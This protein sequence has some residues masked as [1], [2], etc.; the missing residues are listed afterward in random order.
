[1]LEKQARE[2][3]RDQQRH[4]NPP[5]IYDGYPNCADAT[6]WGPGQVVERNLYLQKA[7]HGDLQDAA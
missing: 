3:W 6:P 5:E 1:M 7:W 4:S 2:L